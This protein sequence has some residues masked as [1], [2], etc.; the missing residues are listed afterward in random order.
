MLYS[1]QVY[2]VGDIIDTWVY[3]QGLLEFEFGLA[4]AVGLFKGV[5]GM[6]L[7]LFANWLSKKRWIISEKEF[8]NTNL[9]HISNI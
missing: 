8:Q 5:F 1:P 9:R 6:F 2:A 3:R 4:T 7:V